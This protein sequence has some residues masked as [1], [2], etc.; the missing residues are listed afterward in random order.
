MIF[1]V[2]LGYFE[3]KLLLKASFKSYRNE[4]V[5]GNKNGQNKNGRKYEKVLP[6][7]EKRRGS[8]KAIRRS[9][10]KK[11]TN[12]TSSPRCQP[13]QHEVLHQLQVKAIEFQSEEKHRRKHGF[14]GLLKVMFFLFFILGR[15]QKAFFGDYIFGVS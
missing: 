3:L 5:V 7:T 11:Q 4:T 15:F 13:Q 12:N 10:I 8:S 1:L 14:L 2:Y 6:K 9:G